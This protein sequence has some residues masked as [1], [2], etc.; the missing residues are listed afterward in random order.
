MLR[1]TRPRRLVIVLFLIA[2]IV[3]PVAGVAREASADPRLQEGVPPA[4]GTDGKVTY[5]GYLIDNALILPRLS[6]A[7]IEITL[8]RLTS[9][10][11]AEALGA[12]LR[13]GDVDWGEA[14]GRVS[15][16]AGLG[17]P[18]AAAFEESVEERRH[19]VFLIHRPL[20]MR[21]IFA[22]APSTSYPYTV[23]ELSLEADGT[24]SGELI[25]AAKVHLRDGKRLVIDQWLVRP[26]WIVNVRRLDS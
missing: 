8:D 15:I 22:G 9:E 23:I 17:Y 12:Q 7:R 14:V 10:A 13:E 2:T 18:I 21:E 3:P 26:L 20:N 6:S 4:A 25:P 16:G 11:D 5:T 1:S 24:G 19:L